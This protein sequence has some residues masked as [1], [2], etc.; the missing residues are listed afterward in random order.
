MVI[1]FEILSIFQVQKKKNTFKLKFYHSAT[2]IGT[3]VTMVGVALFF[4]V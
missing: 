2:T 1:T 3:L 4:L